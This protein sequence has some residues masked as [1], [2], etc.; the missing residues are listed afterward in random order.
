MVEFF[1]TATLLHDD[2]VDESTMRR[3]KE[4]ANEIW[5]SKASILVGD[6]LLTQQMNLMI[7]V[8]QLDIMRLMAKVAHE[9][10]CGEI[11]Q[12]S[13]RHK[14]SLSE[15]DYFDVIKGKTSLLF[16]ASA[17]MGALLAE[18]PEPIQHGL[19][20]FGL[21]VGNAFQLIDDAFDYCSD[22]KTIG[23]N[24]GDDLAEGKPTLPLLHVL[25]HGTDE[26]KQKVKHSLEQGTLD[27][28]P[29]ILDAISATKAIDYTRMIAAQEVDKALSAL[30]VLPNSVYK[31][32]M[33]ELAQFA[34]NRDH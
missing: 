33:V 8:G 24:I 31:E 14:T 23:K 3:G 15:D 11:K 26:Q 30:D 13:N 29:D 7:Q 27:H 25:K 9:M 18:M 4:T 12:L 17:A 5:G 16:A 2:L 21:H 32:A 20:D 28:L 1:H 22:V 10:G 34:I 19:Y 6:Y